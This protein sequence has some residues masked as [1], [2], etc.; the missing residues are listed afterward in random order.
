MKPDAVR[1]TADGVVPRFVERC[2]QAGTHVF[3]C[4]FLHEHEVEI[5]SAIVSVGNQRCEGCAYRTQV[6]RGQ[7]D[8]HVFS[9]LRHVDTG[10]LGQQVHDGYLCG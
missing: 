3:E 5:C 1:V 10:E 4:A 2:H 7:Q 8:S 9:F 6:V